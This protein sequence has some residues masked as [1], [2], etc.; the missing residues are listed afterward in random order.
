MR[1]T[2]IV[3]EILA[4][5]TFLGGIISLLVVKTD[6]G[7]LCSVL[8]AQCGWIIKLLANIMAN[9]QAKPWP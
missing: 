4:V 2:A 5:A 9:G 3:S 8:V 1:A 7:L 6:V